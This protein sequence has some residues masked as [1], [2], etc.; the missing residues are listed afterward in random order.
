MPKNGHKKAPVYTEALWI[1]LFHFKQINGYEV[2]Y[3]VNFQGSTSYFWHSLAIVSCDGALPL[4]T[5][6]PAGKI[7]PLDTSLTPCGR[8]NTTACHAHVE[9]NA[10]FYP[11]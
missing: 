5:S 2:N 10:I 1:E 3:A 8:N 4:R 11:R 7:S 9:R 6:P